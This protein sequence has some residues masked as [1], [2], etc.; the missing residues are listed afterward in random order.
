VVLLA[1]FSKSSLVLSL[2]Q[3]MA[4]KFSFIKRTLQESKLDYYMKNANSVMYFALQ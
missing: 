2:P 4:F 1:L 3:G